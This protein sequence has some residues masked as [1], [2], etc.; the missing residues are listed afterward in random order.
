[1]S[2]LVFSW[3]QDKFITL[4][5]NEAL[6][7]LFLFTE[8]KPDYAEEL[9]MELRRKVGQIHRSKFL[10]SLPVV[11]VNT[12]TEAHVTGTFWREGWRC[13]GAEE[14]LA[15]VTV[16]AGYGVGSMGSFCVTDHPYEGMEKLKKY[17]SRS[18]NRL[19][20]L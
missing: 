3:T 17:P 18:L 9:L 19:D 6:R 5:P 12:A 16:L 11:V 13:P 10:E 2:E 7:F 15:H 20:K 14:R 8:P 4:A 1:M